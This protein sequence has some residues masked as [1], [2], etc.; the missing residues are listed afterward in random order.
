MRT[1]E[2]SPEHLSDSTNRFEIQA[3][4]LTVTPF[5]FK[6][7]YQWQTVLII[8]VMLNI[9]KNNWLLNVT[10]TGTLCS[11]SPA[12]SSLALSANGGDVEWWRQTGMFPILSLQ[13]L[14][15]GCLWKAGVWYNYTLGHTGNLKQLNENYKLYTDK[16]KYNLKYKCWLKSESHLTEL[17]INSKLALL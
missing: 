11:L 7:C 9:S 4:I 6:Y 15:P 12:T 3:F 10:H 13:C 1:Q 16:I 5:L 8:N 17:C 14:K 2:E